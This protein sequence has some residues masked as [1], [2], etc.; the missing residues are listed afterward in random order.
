MSLLHLCAAVLRHPATVL[1][2]AEDPA[3]R[4]EVIPR[5]LMILVVCA[6][7]FG[8]VIGIVVAIRSM[9]FRSD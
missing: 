7:I 6:A 9:Q 5:L 3:V 2:Q 8:A 1:E 4:A